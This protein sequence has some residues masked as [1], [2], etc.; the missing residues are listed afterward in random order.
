[1]ATTI[2]IQANGPLPL[3]GS[4]TLPRSA[5]PAAL[6]VYGSGYTQRPGV[7]IGCGI[8]LNGNA[9][10]KTATIFAN[11][12]LTH[13]A[14]VPG[15]VAVEDDTAAGAGVNYTVGLTPLN[16]QTVTDNSDSFLVVL[17]H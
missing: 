6:V 12:E 11:H 14:F 10:G 13:L 3:S 8:S 4:F 9:T 5:Y 15:A 7:P 17:H 16:A 1:M 2:V